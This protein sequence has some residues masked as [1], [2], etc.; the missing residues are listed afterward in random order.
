MEKAT[1]K[2]QRRI[3]RYENRF[4]WVSIP[5][6]ELSFCSLCCCFIRQH[7]CYCT[8]DIHAA[9]LHCM[10]TTCCSLSQERIMTLKKQSSQITLQAQQE[11]ENFQREKNNLLVMLQKVKTFFAR[12]ESKYLISFT[13]PCHPAVCRRERSWRLWRESMRSCL[14]GRPSTAAPWEPSLRWESFAVTT[15]L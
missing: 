15:T 8:S 3:W 5:E 13:W 14:R 7:L 6:W 12:W 11:R 10:V 4:I 9:G 2:W 1:Q